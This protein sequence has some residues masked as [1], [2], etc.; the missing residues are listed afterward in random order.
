[1]EPAVER[2]DVKAVLAA[3]FD[4]NATLVEISGHLLEVR[5]LLGE[6]PDEEEEETDA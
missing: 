5:Y 1:V 6:E 4:A 3:L 2:E